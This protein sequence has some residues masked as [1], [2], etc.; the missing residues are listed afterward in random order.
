MRATM[1]I[2]EDE[3]TVGNEIRIDTP[4]PG[5]FEALMLPL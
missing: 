1:K 4:P 3:D 5:R 2:Y